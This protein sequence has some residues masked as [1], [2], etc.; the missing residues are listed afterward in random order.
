MEKRWNSATMNLM[1]DVIT[2]GTVPNL[3]VGFAISMLIF[4]RLPLP[5]RPVA[6]FVVGRVI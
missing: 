3:V 6:A 1:Q 2:P 4:P 5:L